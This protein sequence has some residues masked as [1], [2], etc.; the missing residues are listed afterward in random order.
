MYLK[1]FLVT[2]NLFDDY[3]ISFPLYQSQLLQVFNLNEFDDKVISNII[4]DIEDDLKNNID[5]VK[6]RE[7]LYKNN[8]NSIF[9]RENIMTLFFSYDYFYK[10]HNCYIKNDFSKFNI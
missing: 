2:Y 1:D 8:E 3:N 6:V 4:S 9:N 10:F 5:F 7:L